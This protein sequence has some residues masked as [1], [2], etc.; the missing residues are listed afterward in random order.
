MS[1]VL[2]VDPALEAAYNVRAAIP[3]HPA[4]FARWRERSA[5]WRAQHPPVVHAYGRTPAETL[6]FFSAGPGAPLQMFLHGGY[7]QALGKRDFSH[8]AAPWVEH[9][10]SVAVI[11]YALCP[12]VSLDDIVAQARCALLWLHRHAAALHIDAR[13]IQVSGHSAGG[14]LVGML[15]ATDWR[16][17][18]GWADLIAETRMPVATPL[19]SA[20]SISGLF[21]LEPLRHTSINDR[22]GMDA[23]MAARNSAMAYPPAV[24]APLLLAVGEHESRAFHEQSQALAERWGT[25]LP[26][27][28][29]LSLAGCHH[30]AAVDELGDAR[31]TLFAAARGM[32]LA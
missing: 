19:H 18:A 3:E 7:W 20:V 12:A 27:A 17:L 14:Q 15:L 29:Y 13:R 6:D 26:L 30:L 9:G 32:L 16:S 4:I 28:R 22:V 25:R 31:S 2:P 21:D 11:D 5:Q 24:H 8:L 23:A 10:V 1:A